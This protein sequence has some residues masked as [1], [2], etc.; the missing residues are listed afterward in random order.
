[1]S[2]TNDLI[3]PPGMPLTPR[4]SILVAADV[5]DVPGRCVPEVVV[6]SQQSGGGLLV[7]RL[8]QMPVRPLGDTEALA[9]LRIMVQSERLEVLLEGEDKVS[10]WYRVAPQTAFRLGLLPQADAGTPSL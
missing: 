9:V 7:P 3:L 6:F 10:K 1:M 4:R 2:G 5:P 8:H